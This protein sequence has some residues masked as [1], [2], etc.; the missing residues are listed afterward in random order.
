MANIYLEKR[1]ITLLITIG[2]ASIE[3]IFNTLGNC[4]WGTLSQRL[5]TMAREHTLIRTDKGVYKL[6]RKRKV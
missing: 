1:I 5:A 3:E 2:E 6:N 4:K